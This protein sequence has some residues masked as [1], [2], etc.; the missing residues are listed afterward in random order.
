MLTAYDVLTARLLEEAG[1]DSILVGDSLGMVIHGSQNTLSVT[2]DDIIYH[3]KAVIR[4]TSRA[5]IVADMP[6]MSYQ[7]STTD[8]LRNVGRIIKEGG[9][10]AVKLE[11]GEEFAPLIEQIVQLGVP[12]MGHIGLTPQSIRAM[13]GFKVQG[14]SSESAEAIF[15]SARALEAAGAY[16]IV[17]ECIP[18]ELASR[19]TK[20]ISIP[21]I[22]IGSGPG[23]DGQV[24][25]IHDILGMDEGFKPKFVKRYANLSSVIRNS[26][27]TYCQEVRAGVF[28]DE[29]HSFQ[30]D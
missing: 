29:Q 26:V 24:L 23:C 21:T 17:L 10:H 11:G 9:A 12:V 25:V 20:A 6:F 22:G 15:S 27:E 13:G 7:V 28:P 3:T 5:H 8:A 2:V 1:V 18:S 14:R 30:Q 4:G 16:A 19:I